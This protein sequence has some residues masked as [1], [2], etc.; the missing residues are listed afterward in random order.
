[1]RRPFVLSGLLLCCLTVLLPP[2]TAAQRPADS[3]RAAALR[4]FHGP[5]LEG[6]DGPLAKAGLDL[7]VLYHEYRVAR[8]QGTSSFTPSLSGARV[9][10]GDVVIDAVARDTAAAL[11]ADLEAL[12]LTDAATAGRL[13]S[14]RFP[15]DSIPALATLESLRGVVPAQMRTREDRPAPGTSKGTPSAPT[16]TPSRPPARPSPPPDSPPPSV[17]PPA[18]G[19]EATAPTTAPAS[20]SGTDGPDA[21]LFLLVLAGVLLGLEP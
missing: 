4:D 5:D 8:A 11:R 10:D 6:K 18:P 9:I 21:G 15:I 13:V 20:P 7:L 3:I 16:G 12:G 17:V 14:G 19:P 2:P 1:M